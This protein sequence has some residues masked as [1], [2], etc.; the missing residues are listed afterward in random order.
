[1]LGQVVGIGDYAKHMVVGLSREFKK[2]KGVTKKAEIKKVDVVHAQA[3]V[4]SNR[5]VVVIIRDEAL[6]AVAKI[7]ARLGSALFEKLALEQ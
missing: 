5:V 3:I 4:E 2:A 1:M 7:E 6:S